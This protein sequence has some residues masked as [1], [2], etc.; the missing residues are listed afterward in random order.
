MNTE[1]VC[2]VTIETIGTAQID[3]ATPRHF[4]RSYMHFSLISPSG[5]DTDTSYGPALCI[6][7]SRPQSDLLVCF[8][9][10]LVR[11]VLLEDRIVH[12]YSLSSQG[13]SP[14]NGEGGSI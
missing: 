5:G 6:S 3:V 2:S 8:V 13:L 1:L 9:H 14:L 4:E 10:L 12:Q 11:L 7:N